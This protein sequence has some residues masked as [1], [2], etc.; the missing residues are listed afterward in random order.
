MIPYTNIYAQKVYEILAP[1][2]GDMMAQGVIKAQSKA[3]GKSENTLDRVDMSKFA[4]KIGQGLVVFLGS[5]TAS[6]V[7]NRIAQIF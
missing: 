6:K 2:I 1:L 3:I 7:C 4:E 5:E